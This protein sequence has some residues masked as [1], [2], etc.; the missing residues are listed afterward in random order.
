MELQ[1]S[2]VSGEDL[3]KRVEQTCL[4]HPRL[5]G[6]LECEHENFL[7]IEKIATAHFKERN[8]PYPST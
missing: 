2:P 1:F 7:V 3:K 5:L 6:V 8:A 4:F